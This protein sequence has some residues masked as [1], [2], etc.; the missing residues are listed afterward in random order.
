MTKK[1][2]KVLI[3]FVNGSGNKVRPV[4]QLTEPSDE[5][6]NFQVA[7]ITSQEP[8]KQ[9]PTDLEINASI[10]D[11]TLTGLTKT[12]FIRCS[13][14]FTIDPSVVELV[15]GDLPKDLS[16]DL[17]KILKTHFKL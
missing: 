10:P 12:S 17:D 6:N 7:Y 5:Y 1:I 13:K 2:L 15:I 8:S 9:Y 3:P 14:I 11:F 16:S 4:I